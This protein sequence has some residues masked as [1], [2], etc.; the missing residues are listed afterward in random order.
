MM[1][2]S[3]P[4]SIL[5]WITC[6]ELPSCFC[7]TP[8]SGDVRQAIC[9]RATQLFKTQTFSGNYVLSLPRFLSWTGRLKDFPKQ[10]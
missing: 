4:Q 3:R 9:D 6:I 1:S 7:L 5:P 10:V 2:P 8:V